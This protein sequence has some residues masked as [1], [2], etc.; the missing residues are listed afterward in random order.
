MWI[1]II[2]Q[3][4]NNLLKY[5]CN[6]SIATRDSKEAFKVLVKKDVK[7][8]RFFGED[9]MIE[10]RIECVMGN[11]ITLLLEECEEEDL[12]MISA[13]HIFLQMMSLVKPRGDLQLN[14]FYQS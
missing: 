7:V 4:Q 11:F 3:A 9:K 5:F 14:L 12:L 10:N 6:N 13:Y 1:E 8:R 2:S